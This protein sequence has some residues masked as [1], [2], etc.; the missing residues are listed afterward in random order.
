VVK[1][2]QEI[3]A[4]HIAVGVPAKIVGQVKPEYKEQWAHFKDVYPDLAKRYPRGLKK[5]D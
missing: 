5:I 4:G 2:H 3:P 1:Q